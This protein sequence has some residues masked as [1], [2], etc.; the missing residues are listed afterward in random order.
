[1]N[2]D[3][4][5]MPRA[6]VLVPLR[7]DFKYGRRHSVLGFLRCLGGGGLRVLWFSSL[8]KIKPTRTF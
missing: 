4:A 1:M 7:A 5:V 2:K 6:L 3:G 8:L